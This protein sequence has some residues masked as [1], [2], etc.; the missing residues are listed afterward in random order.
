MNELD[1]LIEG[2]LIGRVQMNKAGR[3]SF[4]YEPRWRDSPDGY[5]LSVS[6]P[7]ASITYSHNLVSPYLWNL[8][9]EAP[10]SMRHHRDAAAPSRDHKFG[11]GL[12]LASLR[13][14]FLERA[15]FC[16]TLV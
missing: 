7:I 12:H 4:D 9:I 13:T 14:W 15:F 11:A 6:M 8:K 2:E 1:V 5:S 16:K 3:L 10:H